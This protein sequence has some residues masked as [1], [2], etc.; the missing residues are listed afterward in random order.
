LGVLAGV[1]CARALREC[2]YELR[3]PLRIISFSDE[4][5][6]RFGRGTLG[7]RAMSGFLNLDD[8]HTLKDSRGETLRQV[9]KTLGFE[10][11][12]AGLRQKSSLDLFAYL[13]LHIE[14]GP[15]LDSM[16]VPIGIV[17]AVAGILRYQLRIEG[18]ANHAGTTPMA[19][20][21]DALTVAATIVA[22]VKDSV[23]K[24]GGD[25]VGTV[26]KFEVLPGAP[27][28][29]PGT[30]VMTIEFRGPSQQI[31]EELAEKVLQLA[32][33]EAGRTGIFLEAHETVRIEPTPM[34]P[35]IVL[36][37][38]SACQKT[39]IFYRRMNS[40]AGHDA[41][42]MARVCPTGMIF[43]PSVRGMSHTSDEF[44][45][46]HHVGIGTQVLL[47]TLLEID[48]KEGGKL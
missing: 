32:R 33:Q 25:T 26:G 17:D 30:V 15:V 18:E 29:I 11:S 20:R 9:L 38:E 2:R 22:I 19:Y 23:L 24:L 41:I 13:E 6:Y 40:G 27:N 7:S 16:N 21:K 36:A 14:Q 45:N 31:L 28:I 48:Q 39:K 5:G 44:T 37:I 42:W 8:L 3:H 47:E 35:A 12:H 1:E 10:P 43:V 46:E 34:H 4:E